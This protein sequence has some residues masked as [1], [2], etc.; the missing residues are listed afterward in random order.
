MI[1]V[2]VA[3][4]AVVDRDLGEDDREQVA[5]PQRLVARL[6]G[7]GLFSIEAEL[8]A[9]AVDLGVHRVQPGVDLVASDPSEVVTAGVEELAFEHRAG[10]IEGG[11]IAGPQPLVDL[12][13]GP[14]L[15]ALFGRD[16][17]RLFL[18]RGG[19]ELV[20]RVVHV[21]AVEHRQ[22]A[23][24]GAQQVFA[25]LALLDIAVLVEL[26]VFGV[27]QRTQQGGHGDLALAVDLDCKYVAV[28]GLEL[29]PG[30]ARGNQ[31]G[32][33]QRAA[34]GGV[35]RGAE[36]DAG[37]A[38]ELRDDDALGAVDDERAG[39]RHVREMTEIE[40]LLFALAGLLRGQTDLD[41]QFA[42]VGLVL[43]PAFQRGLRGR[44]ILV[45]GLPSSS[46]SCMK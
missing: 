39:L 40:P 12:E 7:I 46:P 36:V 25:L 17:G 3:L 13:H 16:A 10:G 22:D 43:L 44:Q 21:D 5:H 29:E 30:A 23:L 32:G 33:A 1:D 6:V 41:S 31:F 42:L 37:R 4:D 14:F 34:G 24:V 26:G 38:D 27:V 9:A 18:Q 2:V 15:V 45:A 11:R 8:P 35:D 28:G 20:L 19:Q